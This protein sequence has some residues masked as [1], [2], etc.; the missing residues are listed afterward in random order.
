M[1]ALSA[2]ADWAD[3]LIT[4]SV[5]IGVTRAQIQAIRREMGDLKQEIR[6]TRL[7]VDRVISNSAK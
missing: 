5:F 4:I 2:T 1:D 7:R 3:L 6:D